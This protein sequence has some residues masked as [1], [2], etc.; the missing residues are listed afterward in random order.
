MATLLV[1]PGIK[2]VMVANPRTPAH[3]DAFVAALPE[4]LAA[5]GINAGALNVSAVDAK[6]G[7]ETADIILTATSSRAPLVMKEWIKPGT[8]FSCIGADMSGKQEIDEN[9]FKDALI[10]GDD[11]VHCKEAGE[12]EIPLK[13]GVITEENIAGEIGQL[14]LGNKPGR[15]DDAQ[16]TIYDATGMALL[17]IAC[18]SVLL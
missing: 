15:K 2:N 8:H 9:I 5:A 17:D 1:M 10:Y 11:L 7:C 13:K 6:K 3:A 16:I 12:M 4:K 18:A 14:I